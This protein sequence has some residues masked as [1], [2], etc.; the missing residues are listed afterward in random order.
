MALL[1]LIQAFRIGYFY[2]DTYG[3]QNF[4]LRNAMQTHVGV[5]VIA[6]KYDVL[7]LKFLAKDRYAWAVRL[8]P[9]DSLALARAAHTVYHDTELPERDLATL[10]GCLVAFWIRKDHRESRAIELAGADAAGDELR[11]CCKA[12]TEFFDDIQ[13]A[14]LKGLVNFRDIAKEIVEAKSQQE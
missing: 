10:K 5:M 2:K 9:L 4:T 11:E 12:N 7:G 13:R 1:K 14:L 8:A 6:E 3:G